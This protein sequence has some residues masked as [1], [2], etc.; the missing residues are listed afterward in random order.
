[1]M[2]DTLLEFEDGILEKIQERMGKVG[3]AVRDP[4]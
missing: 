1:M 2:L 3:Y 4:A